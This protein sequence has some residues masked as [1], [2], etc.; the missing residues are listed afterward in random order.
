M[1][2]VD[3][4]VLG[5]ILLSGVL[6]LMRGVVSE[7]LGIGAW[8]GAAAAAVYGH[9]LVEPYLIQWVNL[10]ELTQYAAMGV[11]FLVALIVFALISRLIGETIR[12]SALGGVDRSLGLLFGLARGAVLVIALFVAAGAVTKIE[13]WPE[14]ART[15]RSLPVIHQGAEYLVGLLPPGMQPPVAAL[16]DSPAPTSSEL[17]S[18]PPGPR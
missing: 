10:G 4:A 3:L 17:L 16:P 7:I 9:H 6:A 2:W 5:V 11:V 15:A 12:H 1:T 18:I 8:L 14:P 13:Q